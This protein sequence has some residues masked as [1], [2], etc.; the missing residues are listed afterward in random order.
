MR[1]PHFFMHVQDVQIYR[2]LVCR[3]K[4]TAF[5]KFAGSCQQACVKA[6]FNQ[7]FVNDSCSSRLTICAPEV[8]LL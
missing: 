8:F 1:Q 2:G 3:I 5:T 4:K 7:I 6:V